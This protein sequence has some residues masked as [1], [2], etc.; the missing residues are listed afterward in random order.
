[1]DF[2]PYS[3]PAVWTLRP[4]FVARRTAVHS[5]EIQCWVAPTFVGRAG[6]SYRPNSDDD[7]FQPPTSVYFERDLGPLPKS[8]LQS[9]KNVQPVIART[10]IAG[11][12]AGAFG[13]LVRLG[14]LNPWIGVIES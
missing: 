3:A 7:L 5:T 13:Q 1:M 10:S 9:G 2:D 11:A 6:R 14:N 12:A 4:H 8:V